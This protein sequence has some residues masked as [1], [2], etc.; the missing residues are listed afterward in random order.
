M[1]SAKKYAII[2]LISGLFVGA[3]Y[4]LGLFYGIENF[5]SDRLFFKKQIHQDIVIVEID[6]E[7][8][9][10]IGQWPWQRKVFARF[11]ENLEKY[12]PKTLALD[13][14]F[15]EN[16]NLGKLD[17][18]ALKTAIQNADFPIILAAE[19]FESS[20]LFP[21]PEFRENTNTRLAHVNIILDKDGV[22][23]K[24]P[25]KIENL[26]PLGVE[27]VN[28]FD[29]KSEKVV[30]AAPAKTIRR[31]PFWRILENEKIEN[32]ENKIVFVGATSPDLHDE[33]ETPFGGKMPG[34]EI[35]A[36]I[37][38]MF[39]YGYS[40]NPVPKLYMFL[41]ILASAFS[42]YF[43]ILH[44]LPAIL[45]FEKGFS[46]N[47][48]HLNFAW[49]LSSVTVFLFK[50]LAQRKEKKKI[51]NIFGK[52]V[53]PDVLNQILKNPDK[54]DLG[55]EEKEITILFSDIRGFTAFSEKTDP[56]TLVNFLNEYF[57]LMTKIVIQNKG[58]LDKYIGDAIMAFWGAP[59][60][61]KN[62][63]D[64]A[65][66]TAVEMIQA[67][68]KFPGLKIGVGIHTGNAVAGNIGSEE[69]VQYTAIG[70]AVNIASRLEGLN[71]EF[72]AE[73]IISEKTKNKLENNYKLKNLGNAA[74]K[75]KEEKIN[76]Y[77]IDAT[78]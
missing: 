54:V 39:L 31:I 32:F 1:D 25:K 10:K 68:R 64:L 71:K 53:S 4:F 21:L 46:V 36:N 19:I 72:G 51:K 41:W 7:S 58:T 8:I 66:K 52:Y 5:F 37:A 30:Y 33:F 6:S 75:G 14:V 55:G 17:D 28:I 48:V 62:Q 67:I 73:I 50:Y 42:S 12:K 3:S 9:N 27:A 63:A 23:R 61:N 22:A 26:N 56:K 70:D 35:Q 29:S 60:E 76:I 65:V 44:L 57:S 47:I 20:R 38:N 11:I 78:H 16:S 69:R 34:I 40:L 59:V 74:V 13:V 24:L 43:G 49:V 45:L 15:S 2:T 77:S 18:T